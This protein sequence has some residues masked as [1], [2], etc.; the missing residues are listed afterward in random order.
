MDPA[1]PRRPAFP[2]HGRDGG[3]FLAQ[4]DLGIAI[5]AGTDVAIQE[6]AGISSRIS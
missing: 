1:V 3:T 4:A 5:G 2:L 6:P